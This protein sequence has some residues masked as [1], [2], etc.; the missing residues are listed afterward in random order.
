MEK[1][2]PYRDVIHNTLV[3]WCGRGHAGMATREL[4]EELRRAG[5]VIVWAENLARPA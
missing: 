1:K 4:L 3:N 2:Q 5:Y